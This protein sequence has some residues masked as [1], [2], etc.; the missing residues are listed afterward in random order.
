MIYRIG[1]G[2]GRRGR[3]QEWNLGFAFGHMIAEETR[4]GKDKSALDIFNSR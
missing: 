2:E 3:N 4:S 1:V